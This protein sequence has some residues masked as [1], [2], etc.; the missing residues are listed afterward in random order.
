MFSAALVDVL[1]WG[2]SRDPVLMDRSLDEHVGLQYQTLQWRRL[3]FLYFY[4]LEAG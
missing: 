4:R 2:R 3:G 1:D